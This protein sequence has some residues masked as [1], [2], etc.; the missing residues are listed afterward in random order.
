MANLPLL[1]K[2]IIDCLSPM[3]VLKCEM[4]VIIV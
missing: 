2:D 1:S 3:Q 4:I